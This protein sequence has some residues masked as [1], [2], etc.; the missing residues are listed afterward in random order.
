MAAFVG[1]DIQVMSFGKPYGIS[2]HDGVIYVCD[3]QL[4]A[5][6]IIDPVNG[7]FAP[8][9][10]TGRGKL[11]RPINIAIHED[12]TKYVTDYARQQVV[13]FSNENKYLRAFGNKEQFK[14]AGVAV[15]ENRVYVS[16]SRDHEIEI[17][18][19]KTGELL[20]II[21]EPGAEEGM[22]HYP[23]N[24]A[25]DGQGT[26]YV[27]DT[28]NCRIQVFDKDGEFLFSFGECGDSVGQFARPKGVAVSKEGFFYVVDAAFENV[29][30]ISPESE[31]ALF[32]GGF[33]E[34]NV[35]GALWLPA[36]IT[37]TYDEK[38]ISFFDTVRHKDFN[39]E[40][41]VLVV[42]QY[43]PAYVNVYAFGEAREGSPLAK[44][45]AETVEP[46]G[47]EGTSPPELPDPKNIQ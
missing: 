18:D 44:G 46:A 14:P 16:D 35:P 41:L 19:R 12:G 2:V 1:G 7:F 10:D 6:W 38:L 22:F 26:L 11:Q 21:G 20:E 31:I 5:V 36:G 47:G 3:V 40:Y 9:D 45:E 32:F 13:V 34:A 39:V 25:R 27:T 37:I 30:I 42:S 17:L 23:T 8:L 33:G 4:G 24:L 29:Q 28:I 43:G 15:F